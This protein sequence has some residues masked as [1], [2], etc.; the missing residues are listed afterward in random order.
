M[1]GSQVFARFSA[2]S[3]TRAGRRLAL[4]GSLAGTLSAIASLQLGATTPTSVT[5]GTQRA[6][7]GAEEDGSSEKWNSLRRSYGLQLG[8][9]RSQAKAEQGWQQVLGTAEDL[10]GPLS[11]QIVRADKGKDGGVVYR[12][13]AGPLPN[14]AAAR[15][16][17]QDLETRNLGCFVV[18]HRPESA[19][20]EPATKEPAAA[21]PSFFDTAELSPLS[22]P[23]E[24]TGETKTTVASG[25]AQ[26]PAGV[27]ASTADLSPLSAP[28]DTTGGAQSALASR[29]VKA[30]AAETAANERSDAVQTARVSP[31]LSPALDFTTSAISYTQDSTSGPRVA[32]QPVRLNFVINGNALAT[33]ADSAEGIDR[34]SVATSNVETASAEADAQPAAPQVRQRRPARRTYSSGTAINREQAARSSLLYGNTASRSSRAGVQL[35]QTGA[36]DAEESGSRLSDEPKPFLGEG[37]IP[38]R[39]PLLLELGNPFLETGELDSGFELPTGAVWQPRLWVFGTFRTAVQAIDTG[40]QDRVSEWVNR[41]DLFAN[42]QLTGTEKAVLG[43]RPFDQNRPDRFAGYRFETTGDQNDGWNGGY[44]TETSDINNLIRTAFFEGDFG[45]LFPGLDP[46]GTSLLDFGFTVGRQ[47]IIV[48]DGILISDTLDAVGLVRNNIRMPNVSN[49]RISGLYASDIFDEVTR[50]SGGVPQ[51]DDDDLQLV[52]LFTEWDTPVSTINVDGVYVWDDTQSDG[53]GLYGGISAAQR[54][55][56]LNTTF[57]VNASYAVDDQTTLVRNGALVSAELSVTPPGTNDTFYVN[58]FFAY[59]EYVQAARERI[60]GGGPL[61]ALGILFASPNIGRYGSEIS[62]R[63]NDVA[64]AAVGYQW[65]WDDNRRNLA[66]EVAVR[67]ELGLHRDADTFGSTDQYAA[68]LQFQQAIGQRLLLQL[69]SYYAYQKDQDNAY[70]GRA[71]LLY[72][73]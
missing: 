50:T 12:L 58:P 11:R 32:E 14:F 49:L 7:L 64:G 69:E 45:S 10:L 68:G 39:A 47:P 24:A 60:D 13:R 55:G 73:F 37:D 56:P 23:L 17:C 8:A 4:L 66:F 52:G 62:N 22:A 67:K 27:A 42:L 19:A 71:E 30:P 65:F 26:A 18:R 63:A 54:F 36:T 2:G 15:D 46:V 48:Q 38:D 29:V 21:E 59:R 57:R 53:D 28:L 3:V 20:K 34:E 35:A 31:T 9:F 1:V 51:V 43:L 33:A 5:F 72:Q 61:A 16:L 70:G 6:A 41:F 40:D 25:V 44:P